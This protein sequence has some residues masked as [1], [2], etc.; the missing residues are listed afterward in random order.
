MKNHTTSAGRR[1]RSLVN[2]RM[3]EMRRLAPDHN[4]ATAP[5]FWNSRARRF[6]QRLSYEATAR[7]PF[8]RVLRRSVDCR[9][10]VADAGCGTGRFALHVAAR[11]RKVVAVDPSPGMLRQMRRTARRLGVDNIEA[12][13]G[14]WEEAEVE[15]VDVAFSSF[16]LPLIADAPAFL[17]KLD[18]VARRR[19]FLYLSAF[20]NDALLDPLWRHFHGKPRRP[21]PTY[22]DAVE[23][24]REMGRKVDVE[25]VQMRTRTRFATLAEAVREYRSHLFLPDDRQ[26]RAEL[27]SLLRSW[28]LP[29]GEGYVPPLGVMPAA[30]LSWA[31]AGPR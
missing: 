4:A 28:L 13:E 25:V 5:Q 11:A 17:A 2:G 6:D 14:R 21:A 8:L 19:A 16:V 18:C 7:D 20:S 31:P 9:S 29:D 12:V 23:V 10:T 26:H 1:W 15:P 22:L 27:R 30:V 3:A 24:I